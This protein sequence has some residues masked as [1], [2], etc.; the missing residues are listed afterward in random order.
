MLQ[1]QLMGGDS[2]FASRRK[3]RNHVAWQWPFT[4]W[5][6]GLLP[7]HHTVLAK[8]RVN[9]AFSRQVDRLMIM[10]TLLLAALGTIVLATPLSAAEFSA[11]P[12]GDYWAGFYAGILAGYGDA[13]YAGRY[14]SVDQPILGGF[15]EDLGLGGFLG[16]LHAGHNWQFGSVVVGVEGDITLTDWSDRVIERDGN[17]LDHLEGDINYLASL[18]GRAGIAM[19][20]SL[21]YATA[22][23]AYAG[24]R[25]T[26]LDDT[27][28]SG[29]VNFDNIGLVIGAGAEVALAEGW[30]AGLEGLYYHFADSRNTSNLVP[31]ASDLGDFAEFKNAWVVRA[32]FSYR[33]GDY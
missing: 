1:V 26:V 29:T 27:Q 14:D 19:G 9:N 17:L 6:I 13:S 33:F 30:T 15:A 21:A 25:Y 5:S 3:I 12:T 7:K 28:G 16:G 18:R 8:D 32:R 20:H 31:T 4:N 22:G 2:G 23:I 11:A 10:R 24:A